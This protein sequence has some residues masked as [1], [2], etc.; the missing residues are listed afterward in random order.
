MS[1]AGYRIIIYSSELFVFVIGVIGAA[2]YKVLATP[3]RYLVV[4]IFFETVNNVAVGWM[5][6]HRQ[7]TVWTA[8]FFSVAELF[9]FLQMY[10]LWW[11]R[12]E[13]S[14][15][16]WQLYGIYL[17]VW[18][19]GIFTFE[20]ITGPDT[21]SGAF[22]QVIQIGCGSWLLLSIQEERRTSRKN[23][24]R[25]WA[26][27]GIV[28]YAA[29]TFFM[30]GLFNEMLKLPREIMRKIWIFND[31]F[32]IIEHLFFLRAFLCKRDMAS[33]AVQKTFVGTLLQ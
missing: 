16:V 19:A 17:L 23:D 26:V 30:F 33:E 24:P 15:L 32:V 4:Y 6:Y 31:L 21:F 1:L 28:W 14:I 29:S 12:K 10:R 2:R 13:K 18:T 22:S 11:H 9:L 8:H 5:A 7:N 3:L 27:S 25:F 20:P